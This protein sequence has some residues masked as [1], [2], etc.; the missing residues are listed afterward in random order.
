MI[1]KLQKEVYK[2]ELKYY[3]K[4]VYEKLSSIWGSLLVTW[5]IKDQI[6]NFNICYQM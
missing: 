5:K 6:I 4:K 1:K 3:L 2:F